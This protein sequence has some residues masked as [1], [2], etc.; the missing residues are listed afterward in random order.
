MNELAALLLVL[1]VPA[2]FDASSQATFTASAVK[3]LQADLDSYHQTPAVK[4]EA[5]AEPL[6]IQIAARFKVSLDRPWDTCRSLP[7][8]CDHFTRDFLDK[9]AAS[10]IAALKPPAAI[11]KEQLRVIVRSAKYLEIIGGSAKN[12]TFPIGGDLHALVMIDS[13][14]AA[15]PL[16]RSSLAGLGLDAPGALA[17]ALANIG[18][19]LGPLGG[20]AAALPEVRISL[21]QPTHYYDCAYVVAPEQWASIAKSLKSPLMVSVPS[22]QVVLY[23]EAIDPQRVGIFR[24]LTEK[25]FSEADRP[26]SKTVLQWSETGWKALP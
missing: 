1:A 7:A 17:A 20:R 15:T 18:K 5:D 9:T 23:G 2:Q 14:A 16:L 13:P 3:V 4:A 21:L 10:V 26:V 8:D 12:V 6:T 25:M 24:E 19:E 22:D 11:A